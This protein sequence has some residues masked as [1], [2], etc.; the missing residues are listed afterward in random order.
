MTAR[1]TGRKAAR[2][3]I[4][5][6]IAVALFAGGAVSGKAP[7]A[8]SPAQVQKALAKGAVE[9]AIALG[10]SGVAASP[11]DA[12]ARLAL[13]QA[14]L[15][16]GRF[17]SAATT[18]SDA[19]D[20]GDVSGRTALALALSTVA[21]GRADEAVAIL[22]DWRESIP[23]SD[24]GLAFAL[25]GEGARGVAV[26]SDAMRNGQ[27]SPKL[28]QNLAY[29]YALDGRWSE[30]RVVAMQDVP[31]NL[32]EQRMTEWAGLAQPE[33][34]QQR[35][36]AL[37]DVPVR[38]DSGQPARLAL[39]VPAE[40]LQFASE[41]AAVPALSTAQA[42]AVANAELP[43]LT[44]PGATP[45]AP[46]PV[47][48]ATTQAFASAFA[49]APAKRVAAQPVA[50]RS[51]ARPVARPVASSVVRGQGAGGSHLV[52]LGSFASEQGARRGW[53]IFAQRNPELKSYRMTIT[54]V[55]VNGRAF[56]RVAAAG[57][58]PA[59]ARGLCSTVRTR[60]GSCFAYAAT[61][62]PASGTPVKGYSGP[63]R[64]RRR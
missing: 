33:R 63:Q 14:Y 7:R 9:D 27:N 32:L 2:F 37:L 64:A 26:L 36:A 50:N 51:A 62:P 58:N 31:A 55:T 56:W 52:Q 28:R 40:S 41:S 49:D 47:P 61:N 13:A 30:A 39:S 38:A 3:A 44:M 24:L 15:K 60:G 53:G 57:L 22:N 5:G 34:H 11:R 45:T 42:P 16:A 29:A 8:V 19:M 10:E 18:F 46:A 25:A 6:V 21:A 4:G 17:E 48:T 43:A 59:G 35:V 1:H 12:N 54:P 20:L 23:A